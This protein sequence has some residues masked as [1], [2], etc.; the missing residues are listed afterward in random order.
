MYHGGIGNPGADQ[1]DFA[2]GMQLWRGVPPILFI[3]F[4]LLNAGAKIG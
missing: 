3:F 4:R 2:A 1:E